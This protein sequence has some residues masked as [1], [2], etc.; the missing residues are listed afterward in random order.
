M[1]Q[2]SV[3]TSSFAPTPVTN[4]PVISSSAVSGTTRAAAVKIM[5]MPPSSLGLTSTA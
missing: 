5:V 1:T 3:A 4:L 2:R